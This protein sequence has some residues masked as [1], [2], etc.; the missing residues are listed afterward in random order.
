MEILGVGPAELVT[1]FI[2]L[3]VFAGPKRMTVWAFHL[4]RYM[5]QLRGVWQETVGVINREIEASGV[6]VQRDVNELK[7]L[8][9]FNVVDE[10]SRVINA[11]TST[12]A[13]PASTASTEQV[14]SA[15]PQSQAQSPKPEDSQRYDSWLPK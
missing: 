6:N 7:D 2:L 10:A 4:G 8:S 15:Q 5:R 11:E 1:I 13:L 9:R 14:S 3:L 12:P